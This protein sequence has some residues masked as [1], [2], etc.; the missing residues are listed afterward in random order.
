MALL[1][2]SFSAWLK[3]T[4]ERRGL[5][6]NALAQKVNLSH[7]HIS[8]IEAGKAEAHKDTVIKI[9]EALEVDPREALLAF[10]GEDVPMTPDPDGV[11]R[12]G[13]GLEVEILLDGSP[14]RGKLDKRA[15]RTIAAVLNDPDSD[16]SQK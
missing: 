13:D 9:A 1:P 2:I 7:A 14:V 16:E 4:R 11:Y 15:L 10:I 6:M 5:S 3:T 8:N 12:L